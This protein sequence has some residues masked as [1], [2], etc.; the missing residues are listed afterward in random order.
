MKKNHLWIVVLLLIGFLVLAGCDNPTASDDS[1]GGGG[2]G[3]GGDD[4]PEAAVTESEASEVAA[5]AMRS[6]NIAVSEA[7]AGAASQGSSVAGSVAASTTYD[8]SYSS[9]GVQVT[10]SMTSSADGS[11]FSYNLRVRLSEYS[12]SS[13]T[14]TGA[15]DVTGN[16]GGSGYTASYDGDFDVVSGDDRYDVEV[17]WELDSSGSFTGSYRVNGE[18]FDYGGG[19]SGGGGTTS[20]D[21]GGDSGSGDDS[22]SVE[23]GISIWTSVGDEGTISVRI[24]GSSVGAL[25]S[26]FT[27]GPPQYGQTGTITVSLSPGTYSITATSQ[28]G[29]EWASSFTLSEGDRLIFEIRG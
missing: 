15:L 17:N 5:G 22:S 13:G 29:S 4:A 18:S 23:T 2:G 6:V 21:S 11:S 8:V 24:D 27:S 25:N 3:G 16:Y 7:L 9:S 26:H 20:D 1:S 12:S 19:G 14:V 10:G 28:T